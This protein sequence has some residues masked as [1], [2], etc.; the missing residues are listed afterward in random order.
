MPHT[1][2]ADCRQRVWRKVNDEL[3]LEEKSLL[4]VLG[5]KYEEGG[6]KLKA[7]L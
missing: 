4:D 7:L 1:K 6:V 3:K 5:L 2:D